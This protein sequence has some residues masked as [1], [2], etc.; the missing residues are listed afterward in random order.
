MQQMRCG[1]FPGKLTSGRL[2]SLCG[3]NHRAGHG[4]VPMRRLRRRQSASRKWGGK[5]R[6]LR[7][8]AILSRRR[9]P[10]HRVRCRLGSGWHWRFELCR[11]RGWDICGVGGHYCVFGVCGGNQSRFLGCFLL[12]PVRGG[13][14]CF[15]RRCGTVRGLRGG[16][17]FR[18]WRDGLRFVRRRL[19]PAEHRGKHLR[20]LVR[21]C[22]SS[23]SILWYLGH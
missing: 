13:F 2:R 4:G 12:R 3:G 23:H 17:V 18:C 19:R 16:L 14:L 10:L 22:I 1:E 7:V 21:Q 6:G 8:G 15:E 20:S 9:N 11:M 5:L